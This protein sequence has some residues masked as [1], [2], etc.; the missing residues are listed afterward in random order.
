MEMDENHCLIETNEG[1]K[2][3]Y[4]PMCA[5][6]GCPNRCCLRLGSKYCWPHTGSGKSLEELKEEAN[7]NAL[8]T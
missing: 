8:S 5:V 6:K 4:W 7:E 2:R 1:Y 3:V